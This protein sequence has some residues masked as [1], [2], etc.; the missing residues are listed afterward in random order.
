MIEIC[1][2]R[3]SFGSEQVLKDLEFSHTKHQTLSI[4]GES[5]SGK[6]TLLKIIAGL[7]NTDG[8]DIMVDGKSIA[9]SKA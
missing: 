7:E 1:G 4:L 5:G 2:L 3:K 9:P 8:G 6:S